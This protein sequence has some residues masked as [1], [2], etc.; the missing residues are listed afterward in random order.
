[1]TATHTVAIYLAPKPHECRVLLDGRDI[2]D[3]C[4]G[5]EVSTHVGGITH[6]VLHLLTHVEIIGDV[7]TIELRKPGASVPRESDT[8]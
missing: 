6:V 5:V 3:C 1:M 2:S 7:G 4:T 8:S